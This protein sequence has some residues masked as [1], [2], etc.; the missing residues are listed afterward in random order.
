MK[1]LYQL[2]LTSSFALLAFGAQAQVGVGTTTPD[3]SAQL[4]VTS[5]SKGV[6]IPRMASFERTGINPAAEG[7]LVYQTDPPA[8]FY[9]YTGSQWV[10]LVNSAESATASIPSLYAGNNTGT[11]LV[12][13]L[14]GISVPFPSHQTV[15]PE[16]TVF[17]GSTSF[18][19]N[20]GGRYQLSYRLK[21]TAALLMS[22][23]IMLN[24]AP[25]AG[26][27][28]APVATLDT[29]S[30]SVIADV[31]AGSVV[32]LQAFGLLGVAS[33]SA[34]ESQYFSIVKLQ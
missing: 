17:P 20:T 10:R 16:F 5:N 9:Y 29:F 2:L 34:T 32:N 26:S 23:R 11:S 31:S 14:G 12:I 24:G 22:T 28:I 13:M 15:S 3:G 30:T 7:L 21:L 19:I 4:D 33:L 25:L 8:G 18:V 27:E 6:L 1:K